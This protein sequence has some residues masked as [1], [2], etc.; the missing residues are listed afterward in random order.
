MD[1]VYWS[2]PGVQCNDN[3][4]QV[5]R[6]KKVAVAT[7]QK[8]LDETKGHL[9]KIGI[10]GNPQSRGYG[11]EGVEVDR[12]EDAIRGMVYITVAKGLWSHMH[13][14]S[15][16]MNEEDIRKTE[17][18]FIDFAKSKYGGAL[19][20]E[21]REG[22]VVFPLNVRAGGGGPLPR[23]GPYYLYVLRSPR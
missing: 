7:L 8:I 15:Q 4:S 21:Q 16:T 2:A 10:A 18:Q 1:I 23:T 9:Y 22:Q 3:K 19:R 14:I 12:R 5:S 17:A 13:V 11:H 20:E 6:D